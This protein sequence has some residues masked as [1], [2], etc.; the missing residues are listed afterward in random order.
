MTMLALLDDERW[1]GRCC[2][3]RHGIL[4]SGDSGEDDNSCIPQISARPPN[5]ITF[6]SIRGIRNINILASR[7]EADRQSVP[8]M[9]KGAIGRTVRFVSGHNRR[10][11]LRASGA[12]DIQTGAGNFL[13]RVT[14]SQDILVVF[15]IGL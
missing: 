8:A 14:P 5:Q 9:K 1:N 2:T 11:R 13:R 12:I 4:S 10:N 3:V 15:E 7:E 6:A